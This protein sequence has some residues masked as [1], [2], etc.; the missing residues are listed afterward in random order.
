MA[1]ANAFVST[2]RDHAKQIQRLENTQADDFLKALR[3]TEAEI[4]GRLSAVTDSDTAFTTFQ[5]QRVLAEVKTAIGSLEDKASDIY[6]VAQSDAIDLAVQHAVAECAQVSSLADDAQLNLSLDAVA[7]MSDPGQ[8]LLANHFE[9]SVQ[10][11]GIDVLNAVRRKVQVGMITGDPSRTVIKEVQQAIAGTRPQAVQLV[12]TETSS[13]YGAAQHRSIKE[14]SKQIPGLKK[15]WIHQGSYPCPTC[16]PLHGTERPID[17]TW[18]I[19]IG[20]K[21]KRIAHAPA[22]PNCTCRVAS[23][24]SKWRG[25]LEKLGYLEPQSDDE[26]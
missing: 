7:G 24:T 12:R 10:R 15:V 8:V 20:K 16:M 13:A 2:L 26:T 4:V 14:A 11:Y 1:S 17:G 19:K 9:S 5:L 3:Q 6:G 21:M 18:T 22:H 23:M 25:R